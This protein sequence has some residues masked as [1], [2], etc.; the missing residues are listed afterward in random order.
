MFTGGVYSADTTNPKFLY[1]QPFL[2]YP[3][4][5]ESITIITT[6]FTFV[7]LKLESWGKSIFLHY[8]YNQIFLTDFVKW[9][10]F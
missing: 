10:T 7:L 9:N 1:T 4:V 8:F 2:G 3:T 6:I 5:M